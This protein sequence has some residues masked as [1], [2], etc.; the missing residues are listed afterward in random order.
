[1]STMTRAQLAALPATVD[2]PTAARALSIGRTL[3]YQLASFPCVCCASAPATA[4]SP[5]ARTG[6]W[7]PL[8]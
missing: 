2:I 1:M 3:A 8:A 6:S 7:P 4:W 5:A